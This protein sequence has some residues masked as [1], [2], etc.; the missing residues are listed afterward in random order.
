MTRDRSTG[1]IAVILGAIV[2]VLA[3]QLPESTISGDIGPAVFPF[4]AAAILLICGTGLIIVGGK[5]HDSIF[6]RSSLKRLA[7]I[8][9]VTLVYCIMMNYF[10]FFIPTLAALFVLCTMFAEDKNVTWWHRLLYSVV[11][12]LAIYFLFKNILN[13]KLPG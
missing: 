4:I 6:N 1:I 10:G 3:S 5:H 13:L 11:L 9:G 7:L 2:A 8:F 12:T